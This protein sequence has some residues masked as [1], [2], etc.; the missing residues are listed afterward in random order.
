ML[1]RKGIGLFSS[2]SADYTFVGPTELKADVGSIYPELKSKRALSWFLSLP[3]PIL[4]IMP[5]QAPGNCF[6]I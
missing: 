6:R 4:C 5:R 3:I 2:L 1:L